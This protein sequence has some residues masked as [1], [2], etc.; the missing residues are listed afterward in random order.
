MRAIGDS[1]HHGLLGWRRFQDSRLRR[2]D[3]VGVHTLRRALFHESEE[4]T[5]HAAHL[6]F[7]SALG[8]PVATVVSVDVFEGFVSG[9]PESTV[10]LH[11]PIC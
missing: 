6:D 10:N 2:I 5:G 1:N 9:I 4:I 7:L 11:R 8:D 3:S